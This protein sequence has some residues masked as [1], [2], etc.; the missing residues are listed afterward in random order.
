VADRSDFLEMADKNLRDSEPTFFGQFKS[1]LFNASPRQDNKLN[2]SSSHR[3][4]EE[5]DKTL[6]QE[7]QGEKG[8]DEPMPDAKNH[9]DSFSSSSVSSSSSF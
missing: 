4:Q 9:T 8:E 2:K 6:P 3:E 7:E 5:K 1:A